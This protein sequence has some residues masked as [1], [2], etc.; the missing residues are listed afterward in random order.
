MSFFVQGKHQWIP[1]ENLDMCKTSE[2]DLGMT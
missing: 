2:Q 1:A